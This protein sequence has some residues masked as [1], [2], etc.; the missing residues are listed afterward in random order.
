MKLQSHIILNGQAEEAIEFYGDVLWVEQVEQITYY[1]EIP[2]DYTEEAGKRIVFANLHGNGFDLRIGD[3]PL[4]Q[5]MD[6]AKSLSICVMVDTEGEGIK[7]FDALSEGGHIEQKF[8]PQFWGATF[9]IVTDKF[10]IN[11]MINAEKK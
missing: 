1:H 4:G 10:G 8:E 11:W 9:G 5:V 3:A 6:F 2:G 7:I